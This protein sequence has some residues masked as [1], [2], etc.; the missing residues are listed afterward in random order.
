ALRVS[1]GGHNIPADVI[2]RRY[3]AEIK[4]FFEFIDVV[5]RWR[6]FENSISPPEEI[7]LGERDGSNKILKF[8]VWERL[9]NM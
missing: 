9:K 7:A 1:K 5:D 4:N 8:Y 2:E 6:I 3:D